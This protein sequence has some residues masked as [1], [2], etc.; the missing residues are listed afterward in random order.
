VVITYYALGLL[1]DV[2]KGLQSRGLEF[3]LDATLALVLP[4]LLIAVWGVVHAVRKKFR[5]DS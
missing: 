3:D 4:F 1:D 2:L 5:D